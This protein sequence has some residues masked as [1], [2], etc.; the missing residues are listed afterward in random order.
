VHPRIAPQLTH[1][2]S[3][4]ARYVW[5][6]L[7]GRRSQYR[8]SDIGHDVPRA[9]RPPDHF[10]VVTTIGPDEY[11]D[12]VVAAGSHRLGH[13]RTD[14]LRDPCLVLL[15]SIVV[16]R[17]LAVARSDRL[18]SQ[19]FRRAGSTRFRLPT[20]GHNDTAQALYESLR[21][22]RKPLGDVNYWW[23]LV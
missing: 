14:G 10:D 13:R 6:L 22:D 15:V 1:G 18:P 8:I 9:E 3:R 21:G 4:R 2:H 23:D 5:P 11:A 19:S 12:A 16:V 20:G 17:G 7:R